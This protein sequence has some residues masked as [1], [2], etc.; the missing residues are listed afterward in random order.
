MSIVSNLFSTSK[1]FAIPDLSQLGLNDRNNPIVNNPFLDKPFW[2]WDQIEHEKEYVKTNGQCCFNDL[3]SRPTKNDVVHPLYDYEQEFQ[4]AI[5]SNQHVWCKKARGIG[6]TTFLTRYLAYQ[7]VSSNRLQGK[8]I[9][10]IAGTREEF[11]NVIKKKIEQLF[12]IKYKGIIRDSKYTECYINDVWF[13]VFPTKNLDDVRGYTDV[14]YLFV[15]E[16]DSFKPNEREQLMYV[17]KAYEEKSRGKIILVGTAGPSGGL[18]ETIEQ[19]PKSVFYKHFMLVNKGIGKIFNDKFLKEQKENDPAFFQREYLG[20]YGFGMG[21]VFNY[22]DIEKCCSIVK[23]PIQYNPAAE[24]SMGI[25]P[26]FGSSKFAI[27]LLMLEDSIIKTIYT[28]E[29]E[30]ASFESMVRQVM[31]LRY[32]YKPIKIYIDAANPEFIKSVKLN[33]NENP[34]YESVIARATREKIDY[35]YRMNVIPISFNEYGKELLGR[36]QKVVSK[37][38]FALSPVEHSA[39]VAQMRQARFLENGNLDKKENNSGA[40]YDVFDST[41]LALKMFESERRR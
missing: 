28:K 32:Q 10:I 40:T 41:R 29:F 37:G 20:Q 26:S 36:F 6:A 33:L 3:I 16:G 31:Q 18:F 30:R 24:V 4:D 13:K 5:E 17:I 38:W 35:E 25:D 8:S 1:T 23:Y 9:F 2:I 22:E 21:T 11:A 15:D 14:S 39:L 34:N 12:D 27:T 19:D 7:A